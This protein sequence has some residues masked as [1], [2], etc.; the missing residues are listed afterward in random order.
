VYAAKYADFVG[1]PTMASSLSRGRPIV[2]IQRSGPQRQGRAEL[3]RLLAGA[4]ALVAFENTATITEA[5]LLGTPVVLVRSS[6][7]PTLLAESELGDAGTAWFE[8]TGALDIAV[9]SLGE[10]KDAY[11]KAI[12]QAPSDVEAFQQKMAN[13]ALEVDYLQMT[14]TQGNQPSPQKTLRNRLIFARSLVAVGGV[15]QLV[16]TGFESI[17]RRLR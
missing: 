10:A 6:F 7:F 17:A 4:H 16:A 8:D 11:L 9:S 15:R 12:A 14:R 1:K 13:L 3:L 2:H 5:V